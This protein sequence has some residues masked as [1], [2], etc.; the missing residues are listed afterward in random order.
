MDELEFLGSF[1]GV[2]RAIKRGDFGSGD[3]F[4]STSSSMRFHPSSRSDLGLAARKGR[5]F[6]S[7]TGSS[8]VGESSAGRRFEFGF[9]PCFGLG[10][11]TTSSNSTRR[12]GGNTIK[13]CVR[14]KKENKKRGP[15]E[16]GPHQRPLEAPLLRL[17]ILSL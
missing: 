13:N 12:A 1:L 3:M 6:P 15:E 9:E 4:P 7:T 11:R 14:S 5:D 16:Q 10:N 8:A 2:S 17:R